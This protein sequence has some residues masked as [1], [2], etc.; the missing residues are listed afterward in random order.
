MTKLRWNNVKGS[1]AI[2]PLQKK[3]TAVIRYQDSETD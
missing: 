3:T 2:W 1:T